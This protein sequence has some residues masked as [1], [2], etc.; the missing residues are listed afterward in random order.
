MPK[1]LHLPVEPI[2]KLLKTST[3]MY[4]P[5][6]YEVAA[7]ARILSHPA[8]ITLLVQLTYGPQSFKQLSLE[9]PISR[10]SLRRHVKRLMASNLVFVD[11]QLGSPPTY[12]VKQAEWKPLVKSIVSSLKYPPALMKVV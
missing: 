2:S 1:L 8:R 11:Y 5:I 7:L 6:L 3:L 4:D 12:R 10:Q 9:H